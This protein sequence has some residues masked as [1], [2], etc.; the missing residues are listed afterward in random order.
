MNKFLES[1]LH[2]CDLGFS[3]I[4][5]CSPINDGEC[6]HHGKCKYPGKTPLIEWKKYQQE[7]ASKNQIKQWFSQFNNPNIAIITGAISG[8][9]AEK[10]ADTS[11]LPT[12]SSH[13]GGDGYHYLYKY[14]GKLKNI[15]RF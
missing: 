4:P 3:V 5:I 10:G 1:A 9:D 2:Y 13:T 7:R 15:V 11:K 12:V 14:S 6:K 8:I